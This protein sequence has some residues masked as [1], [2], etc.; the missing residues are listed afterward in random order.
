[1]RKQRT[2]PNRARSLL[3]RNIYGMGTITNQHLREINRLRFREDPLE[4]IP[5]R[6][7]RILR[8]IPMSPRKISSQGET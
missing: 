1:M 7:R 2:G 5:I 4:E 3:M 8:V 6:Q